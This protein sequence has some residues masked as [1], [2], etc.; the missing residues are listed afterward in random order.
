MSLVVNGIPVASMRWLAPWSGVWS[1]ELELAGDTLPSG[2]VTIVSTDGIALT[3]TVDEARSGTF[4]E[5]RSLGVLGGGGGW[6]LRVRSQHYHSDVGVA[7]ASV[8]STTAAEV[9]EVAVLLAP[10][11]VGIDFAR[12]SELP[13]SQIFIDAGVDWWVGLDGVTRVGKR[14]PAVAHPSILVQEWDPLLGTARFTAEVLVEPGTV[15]VDAR[16][17]SRVVREVEATV[18]GGSVTGTLWLAEMAP[19]AGTVSELAGGLA[20]LARAAVRPEYLRLYEYRVI[21]MSGERVELQA[22]H[23]ED[24]APDLLPASVWAGISGYRAT[25][26]PSS[27]VLVGFRSG[28]PRR[29]YVAFYE[30]PEGGGWRPIELELDAV[31]KVSIGGQALS[32]VLGAEASARPVVR[33]TETFTA[34]IAAV[35]AVV[36]SVAPG[37]ATPP[38]DIASLKVKAS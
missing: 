5:R 25:L 30:P 36:N 26:L 11:V 12:S 6:R 21:G 34:W 32:V 23:P 20:A 38:A 1:A 16:F 35:T 18:A 29:P 37:S 33:L 28:D 31:T 9:G 3:G 2:R 24:G 17:G 22:V 7:F 27:L 4:G 13:A 19:E 10:L 8:L 15:L 14:P